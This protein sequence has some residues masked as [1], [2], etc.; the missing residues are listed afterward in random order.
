MAKVYYTSKNGEKNAQTQCAHT[1][2]NAGW[3]LE[4]VITIDKYHKLIK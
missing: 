4:M 3:Y 2:P 1:P